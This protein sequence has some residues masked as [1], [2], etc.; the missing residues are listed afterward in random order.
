LP[1][2]EL[3]DP[4]AADEIGA[5]FEVCLIGLTNVVSDSERRS[6]SAGLFQSAVRA[7]LAL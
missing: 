3:F 7:G 4:K 6:L 2:Y 1:V 5:L